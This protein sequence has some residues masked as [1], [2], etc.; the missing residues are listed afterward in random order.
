MA[1]IKAK[2]SIVLEILIVLLVLT[3]L[4]TILYPKKVWNKVEEETKLC[5]ENMDRILK[6]ELIYLKYHNNYEDTLDNVISFIENG[7][8][9]GRIIVEYVYSDTAL[10]VKI[11]EQITAIDADADY[12]VKKFKADTML[13]SL[14]E[15]SKYDSNLAKVILNRLENTEM[16]DNIKAERETDS[17]QVAIFR[18][19]SAKFSVL[20]IIDPLEQDDSLKLVLERLRPEV[21][22]GALIDTLYKNPKWAAEVNKMVHEQLESI[23]FCPTNNSPYKISVIDTSVIKIFNIYCPIDSAEIENSKKDFVSY[24]LGHMRLENHGDI[25]GG[26]KSWLRQ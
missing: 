24:H 2:G 14:L 22:I 6:A 18:E 4:G 3:L 9:S 25:L 17:T 1:K 21:T 11:L 5:R 7:D 19:I 20:D 10:A 16:S 13:F 8:S 12:K 15:T 23:K 26:E